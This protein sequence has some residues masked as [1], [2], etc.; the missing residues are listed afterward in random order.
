MYCQKTKILKNIKILEIF[1]EKNGS[2]LEKTVLRKIIEKYYMNVD[3]II[4]NKINGEIVIRNSIKKDLWKRARYTTDLFVLNEKA[5]L[6]SSDGKR[7]GIKY[8]NGE[9]RYEIKISGDYGNTRLKCGTVE[10]STTQD[11]KPIRRLIF[12]IFESAHMK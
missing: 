12:D 10:D 2:K 6:L 5:A 8:L 9:K 4:E 1:D 3:T 11:G 7:D